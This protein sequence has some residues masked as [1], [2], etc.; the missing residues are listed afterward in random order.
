MLIYRWS[1][2]FSTNPIYN[3]VLDISDNL[4]NAVLKS[5]K[6]DD[7]WAYFHPVIEPKT[8]ESNRCKPKPSIHHPLTQQKC[9]N[10]SVSLQKSLRE[11][12]FSE[13]TVAQCVRT[14]G[15]PKE[16]HMAVI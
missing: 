1:K 12:V 11:G 16:K 9:Q 15:L 13:H 3:K 2:S 10:L 8:H 14:L 4:L 5:E 6:Y 7:L